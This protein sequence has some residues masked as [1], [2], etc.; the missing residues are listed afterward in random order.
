MPNYRR[1]YLGGHPIFVTMVTL[2]RRPWLTQHCD[3]LLDAMRW[4]KSRYPYR[5]IAH[6]VLPDHFHWMLEPV[7]GNFSRIVGAVKRDVTW[8]L[9]ASG[10]NGL[11]PYW[12]SRFYDHVIRD[13]RDFQRH[14]DYIHFNPVK[15]GIARSPA[16]FAHSTF[17]EWWKRGIYDRN[18]GRV[19]P[20]DIADMHLE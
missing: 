10:G 4:V 18:W 5:H 12:Q 3:V 13:E 2:R 16:E 20:N 1:H 14:L 19:E 6:V 11:P 8:R 7:N 9:K 15:H 17:D